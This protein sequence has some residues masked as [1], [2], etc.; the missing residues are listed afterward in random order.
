MA[1]YRLW[2]IKPP[3]T[4]YRMMWKGQWRPVTNMFAGRRMPTTSALRA[5]SVV[6]Y[7][8]PDEWWATTVEPGEVVI[9]PDY[10]PDKWEDR[11]VVK[12]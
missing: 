9:N 4:K 12:G 10:V 8:A 3:N 5:T 7:I 6:L 2:E 11:E 1:E